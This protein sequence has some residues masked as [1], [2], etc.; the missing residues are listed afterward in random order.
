MAR[1]TSAAATAE[2]TPPDRPQIARPSGPTCARI[3]STVSSTMFAAVQSGVMPATSR[4]KRSRTSWPCGECP[5]SGWYCTPA[6][7]RSTSSNAAT[8]APEDEAVVVNPSGAA[9]TPSPWLIQTGCSAGMSPC[10]RPGS[11]TCRSV[12][13]YSRSPVCA[14]VPPSAEAMSW[15][16]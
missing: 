13:P 9:V 2:S 14:T 16:P 11:V 5:T 10:S 3:A 4:R 6:S 12:R 15:N 7:R 1:W 8:G